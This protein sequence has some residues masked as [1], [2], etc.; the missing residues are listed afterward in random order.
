MKGSVDGSPSSCVAG[1]SAVHGNCWN[2][3]A[4]EAT[5]A[6]EERQQQQQLLIG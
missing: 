6:T 1:F 2:T 5:E 4:T 3:E